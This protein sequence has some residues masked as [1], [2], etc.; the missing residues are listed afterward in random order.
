MDF[1]KLSCEEFTEILSTKAP[2]PGGGGAS[3]LVGA[4]GCA[5]GNMVGSL[6]VGKKKYADVEADILA[7]KEKADAL[8][9]ELLT[10]VEEDAKAFEPLS[11]A[12]S[13]PKET[14]EEK[15]ERA[16][17]MAIVLKDACA[18]PLQIMHKCC[19]AI[20][21]IEE[22]AQKGSVI[23]LSDAGVGAAFCRSA[24]Y[25]AS[26]NVFINTKSMED[27][28]LAEQYNKEA[29]E[30]MDTYGKRADAVF[31]QVMDRLK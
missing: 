22:F 17:V 30:M 25:G 10:L 4:L 31:A 3:A 2:V 1:T 8:Q 27:R 23:A 26:L 29:L 28:T 24:L 14:E 21:L 7:L 11:K 20:E 18:V 13:L 15:A 5:L 12:Y 9:K 19:D 16:R 6:T